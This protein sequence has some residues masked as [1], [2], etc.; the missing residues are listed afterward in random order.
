MAS[1]LAIRSAVADRRVLTLGGM[2]TVSLLFCYAD[3]LVAMVRQWWEISFYSYA[4]L[5]PAISAYLV[6]V[7]RD[8]LWAV[9]PH[10]SY[11][12]GAGGVAAGLLALTI[13]RAAGVQVVQQISLLIT[14]PG[15]ILFLFGWPVLK[16]LGVPLAF[17][18]FM[19]PVWDAITEP[20]H[21]PFQRLSADLGVWLLNVLGIPVY[22][23]GVFIY[24]PNITLEV[25]KSCSGVNYLI[26]V[27]ATSISLSTIVL[28]NVWKRIGLVA[29]AV[30]VSALAN[31]LRVALIGALAYYNLSGDLHGPYHT[32]HGMF[33]SMIGYGVIFVG[34]WVLSRGQ[35]PLPINPSRGGWQLEWPRVRVTWTAL[36]AVL[37]AVG[38][39]AYVDRSQAV[40]LSSDESLLS[41]ADGG[42]VAR[43]M[44]VGNIVPSADVKRSLAYRSETG[45]EVRLKFWYFEKQSQGK[46]L[47][48]AGTPSLHSGAT[49]IKLRR[50]EGSTVEVNRKIVSEDGK[51][52]AVVFWYDLNGRVLATPL[53]VKI[54]TAIDAMIYGRT[55]GALIWVERDLSQAEAEEIKRATEMLERFV[56]QVFPRLSRLLSNASS[57][58]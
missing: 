33:T 31:S 54:Y 34:L 43:E 51:R 14:L 41:L 16:V 26:A 21:F 42:W 6:W 8:H 32:L 12:A 27:L 23:N 48:H 57:T 9:R 19:I 7:R 24:L 4:F 13:G 25:A 58:I 18:G 17:L 44:P 39:F 15:V 49:P 52:R 37:T 22:Q 1:S 53:Q 29:L 5:I 35:Q 55:N 30:T 11:V 50:E 10:P 28:H 36:A 40:A 2:L 3:V 38:A 20:L 45:E 47:I 46:E 56:A